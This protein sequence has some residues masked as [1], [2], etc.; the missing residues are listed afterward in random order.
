MYPQR[1]LTELADVKTSLRQRIAHRRQECAAQ[2][3]RILRPVRWV[4]HAYAQWRQI[5]PFAKLAAGP[6]GVLLFRN[7][8]GSG[9]GKWLSRLVK[10]APTLWSVYRGIA[11]GRSGDAAPDPTAA[12]SPDPASS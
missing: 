5:A 3:D 6:V 4:D 2:T 9:K 10:W 7:F 11:Q 1:Q 12:T 8:G